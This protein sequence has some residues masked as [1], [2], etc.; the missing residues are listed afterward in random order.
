MAMK[1][2]A[3]KAVS[4]A[5]RGAKKAVKKGKK[6]AKKVIKSQTAKDILRKEKLLAA[7][8]L[9]KAAKRLQKEAK[10]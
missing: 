7:E 4:K 9:M 10:K 1:R 5:K 6:A 2:K 8:L 3:K